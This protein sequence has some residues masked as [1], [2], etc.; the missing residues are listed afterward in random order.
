MGYEE[1]RLELFNIYFEKHKEIG[2]RENEDTSVKG[3]D[4]KYDVERQKSLHE[5]NKAL[6][7]LKEKYNI[8]K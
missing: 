7:K 2:K 8:E 3:L 6:C 1:E 5:F 4:S